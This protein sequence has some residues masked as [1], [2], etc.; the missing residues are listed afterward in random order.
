M[1]IWEGGYPL[2]HNKFA[3]QKG[4]TMF[5]RIEWVALDRRDNSV[6]FTETGLDKP[7]NQWADDLT[8]G[9]VFHPTTTARA[10]AQGKTG[11]E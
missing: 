2:D 4:C 3:V 6:Y 9:G 10:Q 11:M 1:P 7:A 8:R 5:N